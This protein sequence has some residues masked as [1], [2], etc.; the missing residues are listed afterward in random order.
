[1]PQEATKGPILW[2]GDAGCTTGFG[3]V[4]H[5]I[6]D[7][8]VR[9]YGWDIHVIAVNYDGDYWPTPLKLYRPN[10]RV[11]NDI[12]GQSRYVE[13]IGQLMPKATVMLNDP[14]VVLKFIF[15]N[16]WDED[17]VLG[18]FGPLLAY[19]PV[20]GQNFPTAWG[21]LPELVNKLPPLKG[22]TGPGFQPIVMAE[23]G[24]KMFPGAPLVYHGID[25]DFFHPVTLKA[26]MT[27]SNGAVITSKGDAKEALGIPR[28]GFLVLRVDRNSHRKNFAESWKALL[29]VMRRHKDVYAWFHCRAEGDQVELP[30]VISRDPDT[31][32]RFRFPGDF[33]T[34]IGWKNEDL[35]VLYN[36]ADVFLSTSYGEGFGLTLGE[37]A[38]TGIPV[39]A[40][41]V[42]SIPEVV[43]PGGVLLEPARDIT[44]DSG[45]DQW[46]PNIE[47]FTDAIERLYGSRGARR[48][49]GEAGRAH[50]EKSFSWDLAAKQFDELITKAVQEAPAP[51][52]GEVNAAEDP[53]QGRQ[54]VRT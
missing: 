44:V 19:M 50:V 23:H 31:A 37:A 7:R 1:M 41:N 35:A 20:D 34:K 40:Q 43:G 52:S 39:I 16:K 28:D 54:P 5:A 48:N 29:P 14:Y 8:L 18:R 24:R 36:A 3:R 45:E 2:L 10:M 33:S 13:L 21:K 12:Y 22:G 32:A 26:P 53:A 49:I 6:G 17:L 51:F 38:A 9:D 15:R 47:A 46:L 4:T 42:S 11:Q 25:S 27:M 30:Q